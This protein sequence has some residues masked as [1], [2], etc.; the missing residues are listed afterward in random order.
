MAEM[1]CGA[2]PQLKTKHED[3]ES[4]SGEGLLRWSDH[5]II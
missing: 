4:R 3:D 2:A 1:F 5:P